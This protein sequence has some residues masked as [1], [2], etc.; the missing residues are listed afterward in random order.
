MVLTLSDVSCFYIVFQ[1][2]VKTSTKTSERPKGS[3]LTTKENFVPIWFSKAAH[4]K[5]H[6]RGSYMFQSVLNT[7]LKQCTACFSGML[8]KFISAHG[9]N[10]RNQWTSNAWLYEKTDTKCWH[11]W[12]CDWHLPGAGLKYNGFANWAKVRHSNETKSCSENLMQQVIFITQN[13]D[14]T[15]CCMSKGL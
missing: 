4:P 12:E 11:I 5:D 15:V 3:G 14:R 2:T 13:F 1:C 6:E 8:K 9:A 10:W 7:T